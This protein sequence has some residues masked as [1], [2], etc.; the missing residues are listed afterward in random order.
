M[1]LTRLKS[2]VTAITRIAE[3]TSG[4]EQWLNAARPELAT[5]VSADDW[6][7]DSYA[8]PDPHAYFRNRTAPQSRLLVRSEGREAHCSW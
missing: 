6:L 7:P 8:V 5:L 1:P 3:T 4:D 2:F